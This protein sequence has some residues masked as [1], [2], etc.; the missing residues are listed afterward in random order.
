MLLE[1]YCF[2]QLAYHTEYKESPS[3]SDT[4]LILLP[5]TSGVAS[6]GQSPLLMPI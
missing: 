4:T 6:D 3:I 1:V 2:S 5:C